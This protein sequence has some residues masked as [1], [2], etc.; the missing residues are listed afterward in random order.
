MT[1]IEF[2]DRWGLESD[3]RKLRNMKFL[4]H[5]FGIANSH[6]SYQVGPT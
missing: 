4:S 2:Q 3:L 1:E 5:V 6:T